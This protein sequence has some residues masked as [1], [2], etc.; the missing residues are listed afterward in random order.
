MKSLVE[1]LED[2]VTTTRERSVGKLVQQMREGMEPIAEYEGSTLFEE[3][4]YGETAVKQKLKEKEI[5]TV[6]SGLEPRKE[7]VIPALQAVQEKY[8]YI[9]KEALKCVAKKCKT[10]LARVQGIATFYSQFYLKPQGEHTIKIC[11]GT[12]CHVKGS[13]NIIETIKD[14]LEIDVGEVTDD[15][16]FA[17]KTVRCLGCC[18]LAPVIMI[19]DEVYGNLDEEKVKEVLRD[20]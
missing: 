20:Y 13:E 5:L 17:L 18:S 1:S 19:D 6:L 16:K 12:A 9:P 2:D 10:T 3:A 7:N 15:N 4:T 8:D 14:E 11:D